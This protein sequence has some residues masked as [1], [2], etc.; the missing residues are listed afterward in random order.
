LGI[1]E[2]RA[3]IER[4]ETKLHESREDLIS[5]AKSR[6]KSSNPDEHLT[7]GFELTGDAF[8]EQLSS[9][10]LISEN[11][12]L[13]E[14]GRL[15]LSI[16]KMNLGYGNYLGLDISPNQVTYLTEKFGN[17]NTKYMHGDMEEVSLDGEYDL[18]FSSLTFKHIYPSFEKGLNNLGKSIKPGGH[19]VVD[20]IEGN[21]R[22]FEK[23]QVTYVRSYSK[24][25]LTDLFGACGFK[26]PVFD[27]VDHAQG[28]QRLLVIAE[29]L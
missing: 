21:R 15:M 5:D 2:I 22:V 24:G 7:W 25:Q 16:Q 6:W 17:E 11:S 18:L 23:D 28:F 13:L 27:Y 12:S 20:F 1:H 29:K 10:N 19:A 4:L 14:Y 3:H 8:I 26:E 9:R